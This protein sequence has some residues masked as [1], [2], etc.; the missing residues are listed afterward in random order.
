MLIVWL[1]NSIISPA[2]SLEWILV[3]NVQ[4]F[5]IVHDSVV[6]LPIVSTRMYILTLRMCPAMYKHV[7]R[8]SVCFK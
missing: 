5:P 4:S 6:W 3:T 7:R 8:V 2:I 1:S